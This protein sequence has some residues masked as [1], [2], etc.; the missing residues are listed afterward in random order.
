MANPYVGQTRKMTLDEL[1]AFAAEVGGEPGQRA[2]ELELNR[3]KFEL[4]KSVAEA[5]IEAAFSQKQS[6]NS[7]STAAEQAEFSAI[8]AEKSAVAVQE[9]ARYTRKYVGYMKWSVYILAASSFANL[10]VSVI[11]L[12]NK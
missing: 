10:I 3:R 4:D 12:I 5:Q 2:A 8:S 1:I 11:G 7:Q 9:T 6:A